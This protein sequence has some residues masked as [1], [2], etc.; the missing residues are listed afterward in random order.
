MPSWVSNHSQISKSAAAPALSFPYGIDATGV[1]LTGPPFEATFVSVDGAFGG[2]SAGG[3][4]P[5]TSAHT[6]AAFFAG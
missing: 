4:L 6:G 3:G 2:L 5:N 1:Q